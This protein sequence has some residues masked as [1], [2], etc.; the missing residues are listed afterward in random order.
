ML[1]DDECFGIRVLGARGLKEIGET[2]VEY[3]EW[4]WGRTIE[5][6]FAWREVCHARVREGP[7]ASGVVC[8]VVAFR[9][10]LGRICSLRGDLG[11]H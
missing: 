5:L 10:V 11:L 3:W 6:E 4:S 9:S 2:C 1:G 8:W 7:G